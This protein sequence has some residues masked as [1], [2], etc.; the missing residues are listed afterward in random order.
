MPKDLSENWAVVAPAFEREKNA[1]KVAKERLTRGAFASQ[2]DFE[3]QYFGSDGIDSTETGTYAYYPTGLTTMG[4][5]ALTGRNG[6][7]IGKQTHKAGTNEPVSGAQKMSAGIGWH[8]ATPVTTSTYVFTPDGRQRPLFA[9]APDRLGGRHD[10]VRGDDGEWYCV[11]NKVDYNHYK[12]LLIENEEQ[13]NELTEE[14][15]TGRFG[16]ETVAKRKADYQRQRATEDQLRDAELAAGLDP[17]AGLSEEDKIRMRQANAQYI[18]FS[19]LRDIENAGGVKTS[20]DDAL[21]SMFDSDDGKASDRAKEKISDIAFRKLIAYIGSPEAFLGSATIPPGVENFFCAN[22]AQLSALV[23][24]LDF[25]IDGEHVEFPSYTSAENIKLLASARNDPSTMLKGRGTVGTDVGIKSFEWDFQNKHEGDRVL[26]ANLTLHFGTV[27]ELRNQK[28]LEFVFTG[29]NR[30]RDTTAARGN[31]FGTDI[32]FDV[33]FNSE[34]NGRPVQASHKYAYINALMRMADEGISREEAFG[35]T[36][37]KKEEP[38]KTLTAVVGWATP[39]GMGAKKLLGQ[40]FIEAASRCKKVMELN[41]TKT[42][43]DFGQQGQVTLNL[44]YIGS[45][46]AFFADAED[47]DIF[48]STLMAKK[49]SSIKIK[50]PNAYQAVD[51]GISIGNPG[52]SRLT[53]HALVNEKSDKER[54]ASMDSAIMSRMGWMAGGSYSS[55][56]HDTSIGGSQS[57]KADEIR[58]KYWYWTAQ[59][60]SESSWPKGHITRAPTGRTTI[61]GQGSVPA[62]EISKGEVQEE[63]KRL[64]LKIK[65]L[66]LKRGQR[67]IPGGAGRTFGQAG[68]IRDDS[69]IQEHSLFLKTATDLLAQI[70]T[71]LYAEINSQFI[72]SLL[73]RSKLYYVTVDRSSI[74]GSPLG[75]NSNFKI[76]VN[77]KGKDGTKKG[78]ESARRSITKVGRGSGRASA[79]AQAVRAQATKAALSPEKQRELKMRPAFT[80]DPTPP[81]EDANQVLSDLVRIYYIKLGDLVDLV[82]AGALGSGEAEVVLGSFYPA[83][84]N[85]RKYASDEIASLADIPISLDYFSQW[86]VDHIALPGTS[87]MSLRAFLNK[88]FTQL[89][90][91]LVNQVWN[92]KQHSSRLYFEFTSMIAPYS[93]RKPSDEFEKSI[94][95]GGGGPV[96]IGIGKPDKFIITEGQLK[97]VC[98]ASSAAFGLPSKQKNKYFFIQGMMLGNE[99][100]MVGNRVDDERRGIMH[101]VL[102]STSSIVKT[103]NFSEKQM[104]QLRAMAIENRMPLEGL[105]LPQDCTVTMFGNTFFRNGQQIYIDADFGLG[106]AAQAL[107][108]GGYYTVRRVQNVIEPGRFETVLECI[109]LFGSHVS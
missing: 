63:I 81:T 78:L 64:K 89:V 68:A 39:R 18:L 37:E 74:T 6:R 38:L 10:C 101:L 36:F 75:P 105:V 109:R 12:S 30:A 102:G 45:L 70:N 1:G 87:Q 58:K 5:T 15:K 95:S 60:Y 13:V 25:Y 59:T 54:R 4:Q 49:A 29:K 80:L 106:R 83:K 21:G 16:T 88:F 31:K 56:V 7:F 107:G 40:G 48:Q 19:A 82:T 77:Q 2:R 108:V 52:G 71:I 50:V 69:E 72:Q 44:E 103:F 28:W 46:D 86:Y 9:A 79:A 92:R 65:A 61:A 34:S 47:S 42:N 32:S 14:L 85:F 35:T 84:L 66:R 98:A 73:E 97:S 17:Q 3:L 100:E 104:A 51:G 26:K 41:L 93:L 96:G 55:M 90:A 53:Q 23:P 11:Y 27:R 67:L 22:S 62:I 91:P 33:F 24:S 57:Q 99:E 94:F 43:V 20:Y 8:F 76:F